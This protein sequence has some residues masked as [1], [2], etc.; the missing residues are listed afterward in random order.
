MPAMGRSKLGHLVN[1]TSH[2]VAHRALHVVAKIGYGLRGD[3]GRFGVDLY[4]DVP[5]G[6]AGE[7]H[8]LDV[9]VPRVSSQAPL[10]V[11][12]YVHGGGFAMLSKDTHRI[13][14]LA[15]A[16]RGYLVFNINYRLGPR[17]GYPAPLE[18]ASLALAWVA[19]NAARW[20]GDPARI[21]LAGESAGANLVT[22]LAV[23][24]VTRRPEVFAAR[25][26][27]RGL[28]PVAV[29][30]IYGLLDVTDIDR[31]WRKRRL[32]VH[33][34]SQIL[35]AA[36]AYVGHPAQT[37]ALS[38]PLASPLRLLEALSPAEA[39]ALPPFFAACGTADPL[40][41]DTRR[42]DAALARLGV[43]REI[44]IHPGEI[45]AYNVFLWR[46]AARDMW[47]RTFEFLRRHVPGPAAE[48]EPPAKAG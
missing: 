33:I 48:V 45:H 1:R 10:P 23:E 46:P 14:A 41:S 40:L 19:E 37:T 15:F 26:F 4:P 22:A 36:E 30:P 11:V 27:D 38:A 2:A 47:R 31:F 28:R 43:P 24:T 35:H 5:Y 20:G 18:D 13:M 29:L 44:V 9:Y 3:P 21:V 25:L 42:L 6:D 7:P 34:R 39:R 32:P 8:L 12:L 16:S 17:H